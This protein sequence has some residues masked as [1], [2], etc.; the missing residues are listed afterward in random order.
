M[1]KSLELKRKRV[2]VYPDGVE[3]TESEMTEQEMIEARK[4]ITNN[5]INGF[6]LKK[7]K[8]SNRVS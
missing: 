8:S 6:N 1:G 2:F 7:N 3:K 5:F 4:K